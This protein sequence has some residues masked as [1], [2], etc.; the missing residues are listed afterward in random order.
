ML[1]LTTG[2]FDIPH[3]GHA[4]F[5]RK[6]ER[7]GGRPVVG[8]LS[9]NFVEQ[10]KGKRPIY[11]QAARS[12]LVFE[13]T[14][15]HPHIIERQREFFIEFGE[16]DNTIIAVGSDWATKDYYHQIGLSPS[17]VLDLGYT[18]AYIPYTRGISTSQIVERVRENIRG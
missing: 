8:V 1:V 14:G 11:S 17:E 16:P 15:R 7:L 10:Y 3:A 12:E 13:M 5:L 18:L 6:A 4:A 2:T 9:D